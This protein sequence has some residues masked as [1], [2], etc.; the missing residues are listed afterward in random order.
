[1]VE[2]S[3]RSVVG[4]P[5]H[6]PA[7]KNKCDPAQPASACVLKI[8]TIK[9]N[10]YD[11]IDGL[12][13]G[14]DP[15]AATE[16]RTKMESRQSMLQAFT[17]KKIDFNETDSG[18]RCGEINRKALDYAVTSV[19]KDTLARYLTRGVQLKIGDD[20][21]PINNGFMWIMNKLVNYNY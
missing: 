20:V 11:W 9:D 12:D 3:L 16:L 5:E 2:D 15:L 6:F 14:L 10:V 7:I 19:P 13:V 4:V 21:G 8:E 18:N 1:M 17:G